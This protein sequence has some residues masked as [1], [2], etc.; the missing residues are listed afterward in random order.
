MFIVFL[1]G[2][3]LV[4]PV[5]FAQIDPGAGP[6]ANIIDLSSDDPRLIAA[7]IIQFFLSFLG[8]IALIVILYGGY[9]WM[10][11]QGEEEKIDTAKRILTN[12]VIGLAIII[13]SVSI[14]EFLIRKFLDAAGGVGGG[15]RG[16]GGAGSDAF[17]PGRPPSVGINALDYHIPERGAQ[18]VSRDAVII[19]KFKE[20]MRIA[21]LVQDGRVAGQAMIVSQKDTP[22]QPVALL[23]EAAD[24]EGTLFV[25]RPNDLLGN[26]GR[27]VGYTVTLSEAIKTAD[28]TAAFGRGGYSWTF[29]TSTRTDSTPPRVV[30][31]IPRE[32]AFEP[33]NTII[34]VTFSEPV[35]PAPI[36]G[37]AIT[38]TN[39]G[40]QVPGKL[41][42]GNG[43][44]TVE[45]Q[46]NESCG[47]NSCGEEIFC[48]PANGTIQAKIR[49]AT[50]SG[51][52]NRAKV[53]FDGVV[54]LAGNAL[55]GDRDD[56]VEGSPADD[57]TRSF[58]T[59]DA[60]DLVP[61]VIRTTSPLRDAL[62]VD[63]QVGVSALFSKP[64]M[65]TSVNTETFGVLPQPEGGF[66]VRVEN[67]DEEGS[68]NLTT[69]APHLKP[70]T[71]YGAR[72][73]SGIRDMR[74]NCFMGAGP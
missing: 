15:G 31:I 71:E 32:D 7:R 26:G 1:F 73:T 20:P 9:T 22:D 43:L 49:G 3:F 38:I 10:T 17:P 18:G 47:R 6:I 63:V 40:A 64:L 8:L 74:Q 4:A 46:T 35:L 55:D 2:A 56:T 69:Y 52:D 25:F 19:L 33:R 70:A 51:Q 65:S 53:P 48:L 44:T 68:A 21:T 58:R 13:M 12:A 41:L 50:P 59:N 66:R 57:V 5:V 27:T 37:G 14:S 23:A 61:P 29:E 54:D 34:S 39:G 42:F 16:G 24:E 72:A 45:F 28:G 67:T 62:N 30:S 60:I 11:S 36:L